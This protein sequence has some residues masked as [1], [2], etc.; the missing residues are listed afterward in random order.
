MYAL[1]RRMNLGSLRL[2]L[3][4]QLVGQTFERRNYREYRMNLGIL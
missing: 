1:D 2:F 3:V 4:H